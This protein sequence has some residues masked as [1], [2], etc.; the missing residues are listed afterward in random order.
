[1]QNARPK[2]QK[3]HYDL[4]RTLSSELR[5]WASAVFNWDM[6][7]LTWHFLLF[8]LDLGLVVGLSRLDLGID[9]G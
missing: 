5:T 1:M 3:R 8:R 2:W 9:L 7:V 6:T 4:L